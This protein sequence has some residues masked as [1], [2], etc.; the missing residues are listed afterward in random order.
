RLMRA[1][2][3]GGLPEATFDYFVRRSARRPRVSTEPEGADALAAGLT[4]TH[5]DWLHAKEDQARFRQQWAGF[6]RDHDVLLCPAAPAVAPFH[7][8]R[9]LEQRTQTIDGRSWPALRHGFWASLASVACLPAVTVPVGMDEESGLPVGAQ[10]IGPYLGDRT[11][12]H[13][14]R[15]LEEIAGGFRPPVLSDGRWREHAGTA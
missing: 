4:L 7:D 13:A 8:E 2:M 10:L 9:R 3:S 12:L 5:R 1:D 11:A 15:L 14:A 6:F